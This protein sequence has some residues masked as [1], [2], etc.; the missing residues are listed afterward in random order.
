MFAPLIAKTQK[1]EAS[2]TGTL[3]SQRSTLVARPFLGGAVEQANILPRRVGNQAMLRLLAQRATS[4]TGYELHHNNGQQADHASLSTR[5]APGVSWDFGKSP[6]FPPGRPSGHQPG[7]TL[8]A[9]PVTGIIEPKLA[10]GRVDDPLEHEADRIADQVMRIPAPELSIT[11]AQPQLSRKCAAC[12]Q[13]EEGAHTLRRKSAGS[14]DAAAAEIPGIVHE[15]LRSPGQPLDATTRAFFE[16]RFRHDFS[17]VRVHTDVRA[18]ESTRAI[19]ALAY[20]AG[21]NVVFGLGN[22]APETSTGQRL[23]AHELTHVVQQRGATAGGEATL[24]IAASVDRF[25]QDAD[26]AANAV[27]AGEAGVGGTPIPGITKFPSYA[28][29]ALVVQ[30]K[31]CN[32]ADDQIVTGPLP[33][34]LPAITCAPTPATL[35]E[36]RAVPGVPSTIMGVTERAVTTDQLTFT[37]PR[38]PPAPGSTCNAQVKHYAEIKF[39]QSIFT[40]EG[41]FDDGTEKTPPGRACPQGQVIAKR[42]LVTP[43]GAKKL[44]Q[45]E[46]EHCEDGKLAF[47]LSWG[48]F[49]QA[50]KDL[51][52]DYCAAGVPATGSE[53][54]M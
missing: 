12:N 25:E 15:V 9:L 52:G 20:T 38:S 29:P 34:Q 3:A 19:N 42:M 51:E 17:Q 14:P 16:P 32:R 37:E 21:H 33:T 47:A 36:V 26:R 8:T 18:A 28:K 1:A 31:Q 4:L 23:L 44:K 43:D 41:T 10:V 49:N 11:A 27:T 39:T 24:T 48:K 45:A 46:A 2:P 40:K 53:F 22:Y 6:I 13:E 35:Q 7:P 54:D 50:S 30:R 5:E